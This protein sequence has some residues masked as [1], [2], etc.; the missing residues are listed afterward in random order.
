[1]SAVLLVR[2]LILDLVRGGTRGHSQSRQEKMI[3]HLDQKNNSIYISKIIPITNYINR[4]RREI[5][6]KFF[7]CL[8]LHTIFHL[9]KFY[10]FE[11]VH[12]MNESSNEM[13][14]FT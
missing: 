6:L 13:N 14:N 10:Q 4:F 1:M 9:M 12:V 11:R 8:L 7:E 3:L 2:L 5:K